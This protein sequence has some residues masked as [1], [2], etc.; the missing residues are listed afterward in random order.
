MEEK[1]LKQE[2]F[3]LTML[4]VT[5]NQSSRSKPNHDNHLHGREE[6]QAGTILVNHATGDY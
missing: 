2:P 4:Q 3:W 1:S 6:P 5:I